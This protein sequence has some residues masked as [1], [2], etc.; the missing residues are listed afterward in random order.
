MDTNE[1]RRAPV[2]SY[3]VVLEGRKA[4]PALALNRF[5]PF[6]LKKVT[7]AVGTASWRVAPD[8]SSRHRQWMG[9]PE[10]LA[11]CA[12]EVLGAQFEKNTP[13]KMID[14]P[15][16]FWHSLKHVKYSNKPNPPIRGDLQGAF[17]PASVGDLPALG[18]MLSIG[19]QMLR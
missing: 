15:P 4:L 14:K 5:A 8:S 1:G 9:H 11:I 6:S 3:F 10:P 2:R 12:R 16:V 17:Q 18:I 19:R 13:S 7:R